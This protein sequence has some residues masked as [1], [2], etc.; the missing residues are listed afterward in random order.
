MSSPVSRP[1]IV[2]ALLKKELKAYSRDKLYLFLTVLTL[3][4]VSVLFQFLPKS[5]NETLALAVTPSIQSMVSGAQDTLKGLGAT[6]EQLSA[7]DNVDL[8]EQQE[9]LDL[10]EFA[11]EEEMAKVI[12]GKLEAWRTDS[13]ELVLRDKKAGDAKPEN[14]KRLSLGIGIAF[15]ANFIAD[16]ATKKNDIAVTIY[17]DAGVPAEIQGAMRSFVREAAYQLAGQALPVGMPAED[18]IVLGQDRAGDQASMR[19]KM[20][21]MLIFMILLMETFSM[22]ALVS[23]EVLQRTVTAVLVTPAKM[24]DFLISKTI[25]GT[26][27][28]LTQGLIVM[29]VVQALTPQNWSLL[30]VTALMGAIM[31][32]GVAL[33]VGAAGKDFMG[34]LFY[35]MLFVIPMMIPSFSVLFPGAAATWVQVI[36]TYPI[37]DILVN[38]T[39]YGATWSDSWGSL[40]YAAVWLVV[41]YGAGLL[42]LRRKVESL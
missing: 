11:S 10:V 12:E 1:A 31:F 34:Q 26:M 8:T 32:T 29:L 42:A 14:A 38:A 18:T 4:A 3:V 20:R 23:T 24:G 9:G 17:S 30:L 7:L 27:L 19:D 22:S 25:F 13:G 21:P 16:V 39:I 28:A 40:A 37:I 36:P 2:G 33:L 6:D 35:S 5:V 41:L 15:P